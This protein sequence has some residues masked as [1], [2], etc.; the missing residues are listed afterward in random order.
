MKKI[1]IEYAHIYTNSQISD[2]QKL[3]L[4]ILNDLDKDNSS[5]VVLVDD[6][7]FPDPTFDYNVFSNWLSEHGHKPS[8]MMRESQLIPLCD[9][10][11]GLM[12][13]GELKNEITSY[14]KSKKYPCSL[15]IASWYLLRL[16][17]LQH[18][19]FPENEYAKQLINILPESF[20]PFEV[21][22][23]EIIKTLYLDLVEKIENKYFAGRSLT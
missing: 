12:K 5:L 17:K 16:G 21:K 6:Y 23:V 11:L 22:G 10:V 20:R 8:V 7:S 1:S 15:F 9:Q 13:E 2:E 18:A 3:S 19:G 14:I 4:E